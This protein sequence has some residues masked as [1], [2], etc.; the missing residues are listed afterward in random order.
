M[1]YAMSQ[2]LHLRV[3]LRTFLRTSV[4]LL[5]V[6]KCMQCAQC[7]AKKH[8]ISNKFVHILDKI[9]CEFKAMI[10][11]VPA[12]KPDHGLYL[13]RHASIH[14]HIYA[15]T[16]VLTHVRIRNCTSMR[17]HI[18]FTGKRNKTCY[19]SRHISIKNTHIHMHMLYISHSV[20]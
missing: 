20:E 11:S 16:H 2:S 10:P 13:S 19:S 7:N 18:S 4:C 1:Y 6:Y 9:A 15:C 3:C 12:V 17:T 14:T 8:R 5:S